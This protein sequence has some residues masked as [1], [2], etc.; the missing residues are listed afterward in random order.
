M[1]YN[2]TRAQQEEERPLFFPGK[3]KAMKRHELFVYYGLFFSIRT[4]FFPCHVETCMWL[5]MNTYSNCTSLL[6]QYKPIFL[7]NTRLFISGRHFLP[8][9]RLSW[10]ILPIPILINIHLK[11]NILHIVNSISLTQ[12]LIIQTV[13]VSHMHKHNFSVPNSVSVK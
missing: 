9:P 2:E 8:L 3:N 4:F 13:Q 12:S 10:N 7:E 6:I 5:T 11:L 1:S